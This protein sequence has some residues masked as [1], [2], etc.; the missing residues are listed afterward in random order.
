MHMSK[1]WGRN[2]KH[3]THT[4]NIAW[5]RN[6]N[7]ARFPKDRCL[8]VSQLTFLCS[9]HRRNVFWTNARSHT[10]A[11]DMQS[12]WPRT[13]N[14]I[15]Y[16][17]RECDERFQLN[18]KWNKTP[19]SYVVLMKWW[20]WWWCCR[21]WILCLHTN[22]TPKRV[23]R[24]SYYLSTR[25]RTLV[26][27]SSTTFV[28]QTTTHFHEHHRPKIGQRIPLSS[29]RCVCVSAG[30]N[31]ACTNCDAW[32]WHLYK[33]YGT[34]TYCSTYNTDKVNVFAQNPIYYNNHHHLLAKNWNE[35]N[36][37][38][39]NSFLACVFRL[40]CADCLFA[41]TPN[42]CTLCSMWSRR[43]HIVHLYCWWIARK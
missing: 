43:K 11:V 25:T 2:G 31:S 41:C 24:I 28:A 37:R 7:W 39:Q 18:H 4:H 9:S 16:S 33:T 35:M 17:F 8:S 14:H 26:E 5:E 40:V 22:Y 27:G 6:N 13:N 12:M 3:T 36:Y 23:N 21:W 10:V 34:Y 19:N 38:T 30:V 20:W 32:W 42:V 1:R 15:V 29:F